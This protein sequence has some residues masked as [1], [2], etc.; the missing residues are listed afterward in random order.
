MPS[1]LV[2]AVMVTGKHAARRPF[3]A[4]AI[5]SVE[6]Q[7]WPTKQLIIVTDDPATAELYE[8][9]TYLIPFKVCYIAGPRSLGELRNEGLQQADGEYV[10]QFDD[11]DWSHPGRMVAQMAFAAPDRAVVLKRQVRYS[12]VNDAAFVYKQSRPGQGIH[13]TVLHPRKPDLIYEAIGKHEDSHFLDKHF[14]GDKLKVLDNSM[15]PHL[16][17]RFLLR[18]G[19][20]T[21]SARHIMGPYAASTHDGRRDLS[22][23]S[24]EYLNKVLAS[25]YAGI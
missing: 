24:N 25:E 18:S 16:Y 8:S 11:D 12:F 9:W 6:Q 17:L 10:M 19:L 14:P 23:E 7:T 15:C 2:S 20:N 4:A 1:P 21:W 13:G 22:P 3:A 5:K